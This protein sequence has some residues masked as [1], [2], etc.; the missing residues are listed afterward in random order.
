MRYAVLSVILA[1]AACAHPEIRHEPLFSGDR[2]VEKLPMPEHPAAVD[3]SKFPGEETQIVDLTLGKA[4]PF[5]GLLFSERR[6]ARDGLYRTRYVELRKILEAD[7]KEWSAQRM[8][9]ETQLGQAEQKISD[10]Q[11]SWWQEHK[12][13]IAF[14]S[15]FVLATAGTIAVVFAVH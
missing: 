14:L 3:L 10:L 12:G 7:R 4:A 11:P 8:L 13:A 2:I 6:A 15:G 5:D 9:Y 1:L